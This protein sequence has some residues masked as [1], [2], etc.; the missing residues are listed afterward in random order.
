MFSIFGRAIPTFSGVFEPVATSQVKACV[1]WAF[2][3]TGRKYTEH[4]YDE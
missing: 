4:Y 1:Q 2:R 3:Y